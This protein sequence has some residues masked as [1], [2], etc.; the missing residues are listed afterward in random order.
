LKIYKKF[1]L[2]FYRISIG[3]MCRKL[4]HSRSVVAMRAVRLDSEPS[5]YMALAGSNRSS[6]II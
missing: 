3:Y 2:Y 5:E 6:H 4:C 1:K